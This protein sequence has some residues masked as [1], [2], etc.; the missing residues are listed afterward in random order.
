MTRVSAD[1]PGPESYGE[2]YYVRAYNLEGPKWTEINWW[3][4]RFYAAISDRLL[5]RNGGRRMLE[6]G[7]GLGFVLSRLEQKYETYGVDLSPFAIER[8]QKLAPRSKTYACDLTREL[9]GDIGAGNFDLIL[10]RYVLEHLEDPFS[11]IS[12]CA[13]LLAPGGMLFY[14]VPDTTS[15]GLRLKGDDWYAWH[16]ETHVSLLAPEKWLTLTRD[17]GFTIEKTFSDG[18]WDVPYVKYV[19][20]ILQYPMFSLPTIVSVLLARP[21]IPAGWGENLIVVARRDGDGETA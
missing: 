2:D 18:L 13:S 4:V 17:A 7:C 5:R 16:D 20:R 1:T 6:V 15:P 10:A 19:P 12:R 9:P 14:A 21:M 11:V 3:S 8:A